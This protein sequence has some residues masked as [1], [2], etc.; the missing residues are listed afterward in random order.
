MQ[1]PGTLLK[2]MYHND[3]S[4]ENRRWLKEELGEGTLAD[5][6]SGELDIDEPIA[7]TLE[8]GGFSTGAM[9]L[10]MQETFYSKST[11]LSKMDR[12]I[13]TVL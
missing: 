7:A 10:R 12:I 1:H 9:W 11:P 5:P 2:N 6:F 13:D 3:L 4:F 8:E